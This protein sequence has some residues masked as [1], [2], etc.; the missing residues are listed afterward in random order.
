MFERDR[1]PQ[2]LG[3]DIAK[4]DNRKLR[5]SEDVVCRYGETFPCSN[6]EKADQL[7]WPHNIPLLPEIPFHWLH[8]LILTQNRLQHSEGGEIN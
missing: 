8:M 4:D 3:D 6:K 2:Y 1:I 7:M 5:H